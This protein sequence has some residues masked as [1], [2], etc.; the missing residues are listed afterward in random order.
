MK[1]SAKILACK[2]VNDAFVIPGGEMSTS[3]LSNSYQAK[4]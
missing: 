4:S 2:R 3:I 1:V